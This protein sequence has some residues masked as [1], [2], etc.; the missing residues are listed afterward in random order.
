MFTL[1]RPKLAP[2][3][4]KLAARRAAVRLDRRAMKEHERQGRIILLECPSLGAA[5]P[6]PTQS[7]EEMFPKGLAEL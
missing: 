5:G 2:V 1:P 3:R 7:K 6:P 4:E